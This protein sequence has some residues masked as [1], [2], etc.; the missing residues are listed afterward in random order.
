[1]TRSVPALRCLLIS[2]GFLAAFGAAAIMRLSKDYF[3]R[4]VAEFINQHAAGD[5]VFNH[6]VDA[7]TYPTLQGVVVLSLVWCCWFSSTSP[8]LRARLARGI[9][10]AVLA[11]FIGHFLHDSLSFSPRPMFDPSL[12]FHPFSVLGDMDTLRATSNPLSPSF[13]S[14]RAMMFAGL[15]IAVFR[16][17]R[18]IGLLA[19][20]STVAVESCR[21]YLGMHYPTDIVA[22]FCLAAAFVWLI[23][24]G[25]VFGIGSQLTKWEAASAPSFYMCAFFASYQM[26]TTFQDLRDLAAY[27][28]F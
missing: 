6:I 16:S 10:A 8:E 5:G 1:M 4:P 22:S 13:P 2:M 19:L 26:T 21:V 28:S 23:E 15:A 3:D 27:L 7:A 14:E 25:A 24:A 20:G 12:D 17:C 9:A 11:A 18:T